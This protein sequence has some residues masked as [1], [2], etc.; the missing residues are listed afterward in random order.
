MKKTE[1]AE[2][3]E[4][5]KKKIKRE[6]KRGRFLSICTTLNLIYISEKKIEECK[7]Y[8]KKHKPLNAY[9]R[10]IK[11]LETFWWDRDNIK[12]RTKWLDKHIKK[13]RNS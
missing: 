12:A 2:I 1:I 3:F 11:T 7:R 13:L 5:V 10:W 4:K 9:V 8:M 6:R